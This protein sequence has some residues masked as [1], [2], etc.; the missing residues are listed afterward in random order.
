MRIFDT[1]L[2]DGELDLLEHRLRETYD[3]VDVF[4]PVEAAQT[5][6]GTPKALTFRDNRERFAWAAAK[7]RPV[8]LNNLGSATWTPWQRQAL[9]RNA[10]VLGLRDAAP[11]DVVLILDVDEVVSPA[12]LQRLRDEDF[13]GPR[14]LAMTRHYEYLDMI[15]PRSPCCPLPE[16]PF[17]FDLSRQ[18]PQGW[19]TLAPQWFEHSGVVAHFR[20]LAGDAA[21]GIAA[22]SAYEMRRQMLRA[23]RLPG[24]GRHF[25]AVDPAARLESK[26]GRVSHT[27][28]GD[29]RG[30]NAD[31]LRRARR[32]GVHHHG[33]W[34]AERPDGALPGDLDRLA[35]RFPQ[36]RRAQPLPPMFLRRLVRSWAWLRFARWLPDGLV[37]AVDR[38]FEA[39][40]PLLALPLLAADG[41]RWL[42]GKRNW[43]WL[44]LA[45]G[46]T[47]G[48]RHG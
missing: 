41:V 18:R 31:H 44:R 22:T 40:L 1:F 45:S 27:E 12:L 20:D 43:R 13:S 11:D 17:A 25:S 36:M 39:L 8:T 32:H 29:V 46:D 35:A 9:Q 30:L 10:I 21:K 33:W 3:L 2:F 23:E 42:G 37:A 38:H 19:E 6:R 16:A 34:Y 15:G 5:F 14:R 28:H 26:L 4:V 47:S 7:L 48:H 24:G